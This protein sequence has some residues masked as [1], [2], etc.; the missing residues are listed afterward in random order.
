MQEE[1]DEDEFILG[2]ILGLESVEEDA[3]P[4]RV[5]GGSRPGRRGNIERDRLEMHARMMKD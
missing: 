3:P 2:L 5:V 4:P 1:A